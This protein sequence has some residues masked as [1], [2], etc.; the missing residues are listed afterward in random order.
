[1]KS[2]VSTATQFTD[3]Q[4]KGRDNPKAAHQRKEIYTMTQS[5]KGILFSHEKEWS[6]DSYYSIDKL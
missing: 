2:Q 5:Y 4:N 3:S 1:M 6:T